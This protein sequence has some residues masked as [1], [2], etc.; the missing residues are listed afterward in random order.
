MTVILQRATCVL[1]GSHFSEGV[2]GLSIQDEGRGG[3]RTLRQEHSSVGKELSE[4]V[5][6]M[7]Q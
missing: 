4:S 2:R 3:P 5:L 6:A 7:A 1:N